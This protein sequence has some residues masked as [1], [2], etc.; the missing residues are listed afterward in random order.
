M[1]DFDPEATRPAGQG[2]TAELAA[3]GFD[4]A[5]VVGRGGFGVVYRC[6]QRSLGRTVA[7]KVLSS[8][9]DVENRERF[10]REGYAMG[11]LSGHPNIVNILQVGVT[12]SG[13]PYI[14]MP[15]H[16]NDSLAV[17]VRRDGPLP[18][19]EV[20]RVGVKLAAALETAHHSGTLHRDVK[21]GNILMTEYGEP[22]L[23]DFGIARIAG[24][25][26]TATGAF[27][28][29]L[30]FTAPE[31]LE[32]K[33][34]T[35]NSDVYGLGAAMFAMLTG[36][37]AFE[38]RTGEEIV[39]QFLR[40]SSQP[41]PDLRP[42]GIPDDVCAALEHAM[43]ADP[44][45]RPS[46]A[47]E[48]GREL[49]EIQ[50]RH[51][52][53][54]DEM[55]L[56]GDHRQHD[57][58]TLK[59][60]PAADTATAVRIRNGSST[61]PPQPPVTPH[62]IGPATPPPRGPGTP[63]PT[64]ADATSGRVS[65]RTVL[66]VL[67]VLF[68]AVAGTGLY[69]VTRPS[70]GSDTA[71]AG[72]ENTVELPP[73]AQWRT[74][75]DA[76]TPRQ[77]TAT[78]VAD[79]TVWVFGGL[80]DEG[81]SAAHEGYDPAIDTWKT[82]P[83]MPVPLNHA[84]AVTWD[85]V[86]VVLGGWIADGPNL[87]ATTSDRVFAVR[88]GQWVEMPPMP[89]PRAA[90]AAVTIDDKIYVFG[91]Q[92]DNQLVAP[93]DVFDGTT[94]TTVA[95]LPTPREHLA[96]ATDGTYA[97]AIGGRNL[98]SDKNTAALE[99]YDP[100]TDTW[101]RL[102]DMPTP[103][104]GLGATYLDGRIVA[105]GGEEPTRVLGEVEAFDVST[106]TWAELPEL[107]TPRHGLALGAVGDTLYAIDGATEP[108]HAESTAV[109]EALQI[110]PRQIQPGPA[111]RRLRDAPTPRQQTATT[112]ADGTVWV[113]GGLDN[114][115]S[116][117]KV[118]GYDPAIDTWKAGPDLPAPLNHPM[119]VEYNGELVVLGG[120]EP[121]G[122]NLTAHPSD[123]VFALRDGEWVDLPSMPQ[124]RAAGAA[125]TIGD[126]IYVFGG[127]AD[128]QL[129][130]A[131]DVFDGTSW[132]TVADLPNPREHLAATTDG[133]YAY[134]IGGRNLSSDKNTAT[135]ERYD[136]ATDTWTRLP[137]MPTPR[138]GLG[139]AY[140]DGRIVA[141]GGEEPTRVLSEVEAYDI[142]TGMWTELAPMGTAR[143]GLVVA[144]VGNTIYA[145]DGAQRPTHAQS[146]AI[147]EALDFW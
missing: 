102:P 13:R 139:A 4:D 23:T 92:A 144:T 88:N 81:A 32:G 3:A 53:H 127:Q 10:L 123:R 16:P 131:T 119:A 18:W 39:A 47:A 120:W 7:I 2:I 65:L 26:E 137:D 67:A 134:A 50:A 66:A 61:P 97:Y 117:G 138:G 78:T 19:P 122:P 64:G 147:A 72:G 59:G 73:T 29:S 89:H 93:T 28:G 130:A 87:T 40:I 6:K 51:G 128:N 58:P 83:D 49:Q 118:E 68:L 82:G 116:T 21:P 38:R 17:K 76:P 142:A 35:P 145:I 104:G 62:P 140:L 8:D 133:T 100:A 77:Q 124:P 135:V 143:H 85:G 42:Q 15:Y 86:P 136:P 101:T 126:K 84:M 60:A 146:I 79:G 11:R 41:I 95:D 57:Q 74:L 27:T 1:A 141:I 132:T 5:L 80:D 108:T 33:P 71:A 98:S 99:R 24:G 43:S 109:N 55:A 44:A 121:E 107:A 45:A 112:V 69:L 113:L 54:V 96:A 9:L 20:V 105:A 52:R 70:G 106:G 12:S 36:R 115:G 22:Q 103:R 94:W 37:A 90:G 34:P 111:W 125:V 46:T 48:F 14:V 56:P 25:F 75:R 110:P 114:N 63:A 129:V 30:A 31:V 91:G